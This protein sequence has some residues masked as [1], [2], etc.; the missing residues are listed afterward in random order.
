MLV[1]FGDEERLR[2]DRAVGMLKEQTVSIILQLMSSCA[3][4][5][6]LA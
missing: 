4:S 3:L 1:P 5:V 2:W 6:Q